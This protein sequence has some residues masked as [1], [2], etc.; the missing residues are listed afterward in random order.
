MT[1]SE[2]LDLADS[3]LNRIE[4]CF[5]NLNDQDVDDVLAPVG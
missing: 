1:E 3:T 4:T 2:F 5:D